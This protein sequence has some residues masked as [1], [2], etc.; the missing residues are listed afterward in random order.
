MLVKQISVFVEN[1]K[2]RLARVARILQENGV[3]IRA[4]SVADATDFG[5]LRLIV[6]EPE[7]AERILQENGVTVKTTEVIVIAIPDRPGGLCEALSVLAENGMG[8][9]YMYTFV[10]GNADVVY[11]VLHTENVA[12]AAELFEENGVHVVSSKDVCEL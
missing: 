2:G 11:D 10:G 7:R 4:L 5:I 3:D 8:V 1:T 12:K 9:D 6:R